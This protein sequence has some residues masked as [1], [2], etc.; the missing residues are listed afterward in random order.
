MHVLLRLLSIF[1]H[2]QCVLMPI[3]LCMAIGKKMLYNRGAQLENH[4]QF[5]YLYRKRNRKAITTTTTKKSKQKKKE[6][7]NSPWKPLNLIVS[8]V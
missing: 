8:M 5:T 7:K 2:S 3:Q 1:L 4:L 6:K